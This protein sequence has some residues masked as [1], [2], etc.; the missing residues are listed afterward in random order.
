MIESLQGAEPR[1]CRERCHAAAAAERIHDQSL[2]RSPDVEEPDP[3]LVPL[4][5]RGRPK[6][7]RVSVFGF[8][9]SGT[10]MQDTP[11]GMRSREAETA[12]FPHAETEPPTPET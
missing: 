8:R 1:G 10:G 9:V 3:I 6:G 5:M 7:G 12:L 11:C 2:I 4:F